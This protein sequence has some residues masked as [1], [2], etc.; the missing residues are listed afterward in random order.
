M[1]DIMANK[2]TPREL[3]LAIAHGEQ[4]DRVPIYTMGF[5]GYKEEPT[6]KIIGPSVWEEIRLSGNTGGTRTDLWGVNYISNAETN[7]AFIPK[8]GEFLIED[9]TKWR[10]ILK[11]PE[12]PAVD[13]E[14]QAKID[15]EASGIIPGQSAAMGLVGIMPFQQFIAFMGFTEGLCAFAEEPEEV[16]ELLNFI[17]DAY[18]PIV[19]ATLDYY[20]PEIMYFLDDTAAAGNPFVSLKMFR[21]ILMP[22]YHKLLDPIKERGIPVQLHNCGKCEIFLEDFYDLGVRVWDP[23]QEMNDLAGFKQKF[24]GKMAM[25]GGFTWKPTDNEEVAR[26][27]VRDCIDKYAPGGGFAFFGAA[28]GKSG[29]TTT[30]QVNAWLSDEAY[31][32]GMDFYK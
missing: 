15:R 24:K 26:Q 28:L 13:W 7:F 29:D 6:V 4:P 30:G 32:Y 8:P 19:Q 27:M 17:V 21:E 18:V 23:A 11:K 10:D 9:V 2:M 22:V 25:A 16:A 14:R 20:E 5:P 1:E 12:F 3:Y 31:N